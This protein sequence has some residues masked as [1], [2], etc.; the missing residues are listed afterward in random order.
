MSKGRFLLCSSFTNLILF[1]IVL[2][3]NNMSTLVGHFVAS[4]KEREKRDRRDSRGDESEGQ[5]RKR[6]KN[7]REETEEIKTFATT[8]TCYKDSK[9]CP[10]A[11]TVG[12]L[13]D[14]RYTTSLPHPTTSIIW[15]YLEKISKLCKEM[16]QPTK[17]RKSIHCFNPFKPSI[18]YKGL[19]QIV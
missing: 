7:E 13:S 6:N 16:Q 2:G 10:I 5:G 3:F 14:A 19:W 1:L 18:P 17:A 12:H 8:L 15:L 4:P 9:P 11:S